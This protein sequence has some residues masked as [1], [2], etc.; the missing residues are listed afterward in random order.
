MGFAVATKLAMVCLRTVFITLTL[1]ATRSA[2]LIDSRQAHAVDVG[3]ITGANPIRKVVTMLQSMQKKVE[4]EAEREKELYDKF[5]CYCK[6]SGGDLSKSIADA[7]TKVPALGAEIE[8][9]AAK[10]KQYE[11]D[12]KQHQDAKAFAKN[13]ATLKGDINALNAA[14]KAISGGMSGNFLQTRGA[15]ILERLLVVKQESMLEADREDI[16]AFLEGGSATGY[17][18]QSGQIVGIL[19]EMNDEFGKDLKD[20]IAAEQEAIKSYDG[21]MAAKTR[22]VNALTKAIETKTVKVG[23]LAVSIANMKN[24]LT[25]TETALIEDQKFLADLEKNCATK[26]KEWDERTK[27]RSEELAAI[28]DTIQV[29]NSDEALE[30]F[31]KTLP[32]A[33][34]FVQVGDSSNNLWSK[35]LKILGTIKHTKYTQSFEPSLDFITLAIRG[36]K[37]GFEKVIKMIDDMVVTL[38]TEQSEDD[39]KK[40]YCGKQLDT[41]DDKKKELEQQIS[42]LDTSITE[43]ED[44]VA[45][46]ADEIK[47]LNENIKKLDKM[48]TEST[49]QREQEHEEFNEL[50]ASDSAAKEIL[51]F[52]VNRLQKFYNPKLYKPPPKVE[53]AMAQVSAHSHGREAPPPPPETYG[54]YSKKSEEN[55]GVVAMINLLVKDLDKEMAIAETTEEDSQK[56]YEE[57]MKDS[58]EKR[59]EM[60]KSLTTKAAAKATLESELQSSKDSK[61]S[62]SKE[63]SGTMQYLAQLHN[64]CDWLLQYFDMRKTARSDEIDALG[65]AKAVLSGADFS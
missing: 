38:K 15:R 20:A 51:K 62:A 16:K 45:T 47:K 24:D 52:A 44:A 65:R 11:E 59:A 41:T 9:A 13:E 34:S 50:M 21:L 14:I 58:A 27:T 10:K 54:A 7:E 25:D 64:E 37:I 63:L 39:R 17:V 36:K 26:T 28:A 23:E 19:K 12:L 30:L 56:D 29:L 18:P 61:A 42:D 57:L 60:S 40:D 8:A 6:N 46:T 55:N 35:A 4:V 43:A 49:G 31:K 33:A 2:A 1:G 3:T 32:G 22:E 5:M 48:V 53:P